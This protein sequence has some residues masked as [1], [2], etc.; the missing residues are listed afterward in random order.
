VQITGSID[1]SLFF[2]CHYLAVKNGLHEKSRPQKGRVFVCVEM[3]Y[4]PIYFFA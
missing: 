3:G 1:A 4:A 2:V